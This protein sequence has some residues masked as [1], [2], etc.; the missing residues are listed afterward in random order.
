MSW[1]LFLDDE[2]V[3]E[4]DDFEVAPSFN[5][6]VKLVKKLGF[7][8]FVAFDFSLK[9]SEKSGLDFAR[10]LIRRDR[11]SNGTL[12]PADFAFVCH[13]SDP[14]GKVQIERL[15]SGYLAS[16]KPKL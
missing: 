16:K 14:N 6:A 9:Y 8:A 2:R 4:T 15:M 10:W 1:K 3:P 5:E 7:P 12:M 11:L 13:S